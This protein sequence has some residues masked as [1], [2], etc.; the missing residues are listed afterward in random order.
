MTKHKLVFA[1]L[2]RR[3]VQAIGLSAIV[4]GIVTFSLVS[5]TQTD[6]KNSDSRA[7]LGGVGLVT[8]FFGAGTLAAS[9][10]SYE[11]RQANKLKKLQADR[12][13]LERCRRA[14]YKK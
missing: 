13:W 2:G 6:P 12:L 4:L 14:P 3:K 11:E 10:P 1:K 8:F 7:V 5:T 9:L